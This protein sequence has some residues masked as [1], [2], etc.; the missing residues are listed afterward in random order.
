MKKMD[1]FRFNIKAF[2]DAY[3]ESKITAERRTG[4][5]IARAMIKEGKYSPDQI[6]GYTGFTV[7]EVKALDEDKT[8]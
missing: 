7:D 1:E 8:E 3:N 2:K 4:L 6:A 5:N